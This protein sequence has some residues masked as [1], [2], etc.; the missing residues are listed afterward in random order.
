MSATFV[1][2]ALT[3]VGPRLLRVV[4]YYQLNTITSGIQ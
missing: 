2:C 4:N 3:I 1:P